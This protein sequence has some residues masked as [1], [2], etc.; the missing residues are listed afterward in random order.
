MFMRKLWLVGTI[1]LVLLLV[2]L[3]IRWR[4]KP[5]ETTSALPPPV[6]ATVTR[7]HIDPPPAISL[8]INRANEVTL[9]RGTPM[10]LTVSIVN[11]RAMIADAQ[12]RS[13]RVYVQQ[14]R[15]AAGRGEMPKE[16]VEAEIARMDLAPEVSAISL[17]DDT[18]PWDCFLQLSQIL[19]DGTLHPL[20][21]T[22]KLVRP[23]QAK[24]IT[25]TAHTEAELT[26]VVEPSSAEQIPPGDYAIASAL[27]VPANRGVTPGAWTGQAESDPVKVIIRD[28]PARLSSGDEEKL[29]L[30]FAAYFYE[31]GDFIEAAKRAQSALA[32]NPNSIAAAIAVGDAR[33][34][35]GDLKA[36]LEAFQKATTEYYRQHPKSFEPPTL[37]IS[38]IADIEATMVGE[39]PSGSPP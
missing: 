11:H 22:T 4:K 30:H 14:L 5:A 29:D 15:A 7:K 1:I 3:L 34:A 24:R 25:L 6:A 17:G 37:L 36:A 19:L 23:A 18:A 9:Y 10:V 26:F 12:E 13:D 32:V 8:Q 38:R 31:S 27:N 16:N 35:H 28:K 2:A 33:R 20:K 21:W 39:S